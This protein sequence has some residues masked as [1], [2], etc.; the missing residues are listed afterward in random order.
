MHIQQ[1][2]TRQKLVLCSPPHSKW[3]AVMLQAFAWN[4]IVA[5]LRDLKAGRPAVIPQ[6]DFVTS[7][8]HP[9]SVPVQSADV[10]L[11]DGILAFYS[12]GAPRLLIP[13]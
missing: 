8:R 4:E 2:C 12:A 7:A 5:T 11:F 3:R 1:S 10:V 9:E 6:Y 13:T